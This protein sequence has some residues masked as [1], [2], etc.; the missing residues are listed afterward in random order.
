MPKPLC[1]AGIAVRPHAGTLCRAG[2]TTFAV[3]KLSQ[4]EQGGAIWFRGFELM[5]AKEGF[6]KFYE[7]LELNPCQ[8]PLASVGAR[9]VV[10]KK[11]AMYEAVNKPSRAKF[12]VD[13]HNDCNVRLRKPVWSYEAVH[14]LYRRAPAPDAGLS[15]VVTARNGRW[16]R[17]K[18]YYIFNNWCISCKSRWWRWFKL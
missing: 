4:L 1:H 8:D 11:G 15:L 2:R 9:A 17:R 7:L 3:V 10:D 5:K 6:Q 13:M 12:F 14:S 18:W 16:T